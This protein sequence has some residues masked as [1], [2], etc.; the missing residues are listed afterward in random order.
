MFLTVH[1]SVGALI[2][3]A[4]GEPLSAFVLGVA[5]HLAF[6]AIPHGDSRLFGNLPRRAFIGA[7]FRTALIDGVI[8]IFV[9]ALLALTHRLP[10]VYAVAFGAA[11][12]VIP[13]II[14]GFSI[15]FPR[16]IFL[17][18]IR[19]AHER[20]HCAFFRRDFSFSAGLTLQVAILILTILA[21]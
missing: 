5:S 9:L 14:S 21:L 2:G 19:A 1:G 11:G 7:M 3:A 18:R 17:E 6:D 10:V 16:I 12:A 15:L 8:L 13:D 20:V 4:T